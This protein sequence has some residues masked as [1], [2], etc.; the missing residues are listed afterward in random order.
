M[1][2]WAFAVALIL[3]CLALIAPGSLSLP[4][5]YWTALGLLL[6]KIVNPVVLTLLYFVV[7]T[8]IA[9]IMRARGK[10]SLR[11]NPQPSAT[12]YWID[13]SKE[14]FEPASMRQQY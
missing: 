10:D 3:A 14:L 6:G 2:L 13:Q 8:P 12:S 7:F 1:R 4:N 5:R 11:L 9:L